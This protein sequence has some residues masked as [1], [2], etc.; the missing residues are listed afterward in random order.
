MRR[1]YVLII[2]SFE[3]FVSPLTTVTEKVNYSRQSV[4]TTEKLDDNSEFF[5]NRNSANFLTDVTS[6]VLRWVSVSTALSSRETSSAYSFV[7]LLASCISSSSSFS[8]MTFG[9]RHMNNSSVS[10]SDWKV[11]ASSAG[12][13]WSRRLYVEHFVALLYW[14][15]PDITW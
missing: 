11:N 8:S 13:L 2:F 7:R 5:T 3:K 1:R 10:R 9:F 14:V 12:K 6:Q 15:Q 4:M